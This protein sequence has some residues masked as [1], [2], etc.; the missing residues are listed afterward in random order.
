MEGIYTAL[1][2]VSDHCSI[3]IALT[4]KIVGDNSVPPLE[5]FAATMRKENGIA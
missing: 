3:G 4:S 2:E 5:K 1:S